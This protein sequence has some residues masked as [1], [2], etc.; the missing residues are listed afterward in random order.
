MEI[1]AEFP[2]STESVGEARRLAGRTLEDWNCP[3]LV[4]TVALVVSELVGNA[5]LHAGSPPTFAMVLTA[6]RLRIEVGDDQPDLPRGAPREPLADGGRGLLIVASLVEAWGV[7]STATGKV[8]WV[9]ITAPSP[10]SPARR[11]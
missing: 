10:L 6:G 5:V 7:E 11:G 8:V 2:A 3:D 9:E 4:D 1:R